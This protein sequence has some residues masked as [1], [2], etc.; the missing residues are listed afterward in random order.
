MLS[1]NYLQC[2][3]RAPESAGRASGRGWALWGHRWRRWTGGP[4]RTSVS[5][6]WWPASWSCTAERTAAKTSRSSL[7][8]RVRREKKVGDGE[9]L[10][11]TGPPSK[12]RSLPSLLAPFRS[13]SVTAGMERRKKG[14][15]GERLFK[16]QPRSVRLPSHHHAHT[17][18]SAHRHLSPREEVGND[19]LASL[20][21]SSTSQP[22]EEAG[23][24]EQ[25]HGGGGQ[26]DAP[27]ADARTALPQ[28]C[29]PL[30]LTLYWTS[31]MAVAS[32]SSL[33]PPSWRGFV[34]AALELIRIFKFFPYR[35]KINIYLT[36]AVL[37]KE[38]C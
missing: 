18:L 37:L 35:A 8:L 25:T 29:Q 34:A 26:T 17:L 11:Y 13:K 1:T 22:A 36:H 30:R 38:G 33:I 23:C 3:R 24:S 27:L 14:E 19:S 20:A 9:V 21:V 4:T 28:L 2:I 15:G 5:P 31:N 12:T 10:T 6:A 32:E 7:S 16:T